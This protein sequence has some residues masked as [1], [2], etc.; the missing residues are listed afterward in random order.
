M[1]RDTLVTR[2]NN[3]FALWLAL[4]FTITSVFSAIIPTV[5]IA[6]QSS[7]VDFESPIIEHEAQDGG[8]IGS[9]EVFGATVVDN[10]KIDRVVV[11]YRF[12]G[13]TE[14][15]EL[16]MREVAQSSFYSAKVDTANVRLD[17]EAIEYY[18]QAEDASGNIVLKGFAFQPLTRVFEA[19]SPV[20]PEPEFEPEVNVA[21]TEP[22]FVDPSVSSSSINWW[23]V[24][25]G[26]LLV[27]GIAAAA[28]SDSGGP[29]TNTGEDCNGGCTVNLTF[30]RP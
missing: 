19:A 24:G 15:A 14:F 29:S 11:F 7:S 10:D 9:V 8:P 22:E 12:S 3:R 30:D 13:E 28:N 26:V 18:I 2:C 23:Y 6:Q 20:E 27:G 16:P 21:S 5:A 25:L 17:T 4:W 1:V